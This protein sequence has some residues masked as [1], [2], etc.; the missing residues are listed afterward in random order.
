MYPANDNLLQLTDELSS[1]A[2]HVLLHIA[3]YWPHSWDMKDAEL[4]F[5]DANN[6]TVI[7]LYKYSN[8]GL[9]V[10]KDAAVAGHV[11]QE[12]VSRFHGRDIADAVSLS[13][14]DIEVADV[15]GFV[16][17]LLAPEIELVVS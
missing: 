9:T 5:N 15:P 11:K 7:R 10:G 17:L 4:C 14:D 8:E 6:R 12:L 16:E 13:F 3:L 1:H 2:L